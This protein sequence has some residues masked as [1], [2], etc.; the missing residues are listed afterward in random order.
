[1]QLVFFRQRGRHT[2]REHFV[3]VAGHTR[4]S[5]DAGK[6]Q[7]ESE[8]PTFDGV[9]E[10]PGGTI[11]VLSSHDQVLLQIGVESARTRVQIWANDTS[12]PDRIDI[13]VSARE[14]AG[15]GVSAV[16]EPARA[17]RGTL[18]RRGSRAL[19]YPSQ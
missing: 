15:V 12:E 3:G 9:L 4:I 18:E 13:W 1:L 8:A 19:S 14:N 7:G 17:S 10:T 11:A 5:L 16:L 2:G 6:R